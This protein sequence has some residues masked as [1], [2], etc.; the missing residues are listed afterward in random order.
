VVGR[1]VVY[2]TRIV[3]YIPRIVVYI[4]QTAVYLWIDIDFSA[5]EYMLQY[6]GPSIVY[7]GQ[8][9]RISWKKLGG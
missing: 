4:P 6:K 3:V 9:V 8:S 1:I 7:M 5:K 2:I